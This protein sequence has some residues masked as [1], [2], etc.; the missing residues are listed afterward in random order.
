MD[1]RA[2]RRPSGPA[3]TEAVAAD[4]QFPEGTIFIGDNLYFVDYARSSVLRLVGGRTEVVWR[5]PGCGANGLVAVPNGCWLRAL[6][7]GRS[8]KSLRPVRRWPRSVKTT[9][10]SLS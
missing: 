7:A 9:V 3:G 6:T 1:R 4:L 8:L 2:D 10:D 5:Q